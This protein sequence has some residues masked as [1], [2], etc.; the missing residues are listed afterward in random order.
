MLKH[1]EKVGLKRDLFL[2]QVAHQ[3]PSFCHLGKSSQGAGQAASL[4]GAVFTFVALPTQG[5]GGWGSDCQMGKQ[6]WDTVAAGA[7]PL[8]RGLLP[9]LLSPPGP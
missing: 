3:P 7:S 2:P 8:L 9:P 4:P 1:T 6:S 5:G